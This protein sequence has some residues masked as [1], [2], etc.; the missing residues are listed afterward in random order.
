MTSKCEH[1]NV[2]C[3][4][5]DYYPNNEVILMG[6]CH[7]PIRECLDCGYKNEVKKEYE[8]A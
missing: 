5:C 6:S 4:V 8:N 3:S 2:R 1:K 7:H